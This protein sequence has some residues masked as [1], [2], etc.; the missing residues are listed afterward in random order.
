MMVAILRAVATWQRA[1]RRSSAVLASFSRSRTCAV[2]RS[3]MRQRVG[4]RC[5]LAE[6]LNKSEEMTRLPQEF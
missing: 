3:R 6:I 1:A 4:S 5:M 2:S